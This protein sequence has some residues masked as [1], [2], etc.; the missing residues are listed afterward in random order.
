MAMFCLECWNRINE[1]ED[2]SQKYIISKELD[3]C[4]GCGELK[5]VIIAKRKFYYLNRLLARLLMPYL[6]YK[7]NIK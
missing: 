5:Q 1:T 3:L 2:S 4:E 6:I 7:Y